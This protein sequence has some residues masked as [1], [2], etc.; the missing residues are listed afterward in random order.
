MVTENAIKV[1]TDFEFLGDFN[2]KIFD[3]AIFA[4]NVQEFLYKINFKPIE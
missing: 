1:W 4:L 2:F 3:W